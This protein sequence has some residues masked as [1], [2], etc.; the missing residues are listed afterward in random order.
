MFQGLGEGFVGVLEEYRRLI[1]AAVAAHGG[2]EVK[3]EGDG[4]FIAFGD[5]VEAVEACAD[6]QR[7]LTAYGWPPDGEV[8]VRMGLHT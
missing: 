4:F 6:A 1:R 3:T 2:F 5:A 8:R 7:A